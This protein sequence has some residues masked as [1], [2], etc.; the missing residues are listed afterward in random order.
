VEPI[1]ISGSSESDEP[2]KLQSI[3]S[4]FAHLRYDIFVYR[5]SDTLPA[6]PVMLIMSEPTDPTAQAV[7]RLLLSPAWW[8]HHHE[9]PAAGIDSFVKGR[10]QVE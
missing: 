5:K 8:K 1:R 4:R 9:D 10:R 3:S 6:R 7:A 2:N